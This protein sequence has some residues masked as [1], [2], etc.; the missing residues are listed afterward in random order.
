MY[1]LSDP[2]CTICVVIGGI[3]CLWSNPI[4]QIHPCTASQSPISIMNFRFP[5]PVRCREMRVR[6]GRDVTLLLL[7]HDVYTGAP[8][9][10]HNT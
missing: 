7:F 10:Q 3:S 2:S 5:L 1:S 6:E 9:K 4:P 8:F